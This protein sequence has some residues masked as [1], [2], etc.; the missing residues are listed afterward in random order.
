MEN[1]KTNKMV[2]ELLFK[3]ALDE[4]LSNLTASSNDNKVALQ[5]F[6]STS[7]ICIATGVNSVGAK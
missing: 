7:Q 6:M 1:K 2:Q 4:C 3:G 5:F